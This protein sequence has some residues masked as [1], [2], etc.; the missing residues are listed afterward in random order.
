MPEGADVKVAIATC[1]LVLAK[2]PWSERARG[3]LVVE[4]RTRHAMTL[5]DLAAWTAKT[6]G[7]PKDVA[8]RRDV[9]TILHE[10]KAIMRRRE[11]R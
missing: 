9:Q 1:F 11:R 7:A 6:G 5:E 2:Q 3:P 10:L 8:L 4:V